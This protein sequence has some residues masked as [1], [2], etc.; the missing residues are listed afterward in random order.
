MK[1]NCLDIGII[2]AF[3]DGELVHEETARVSGHIATCDASALMLADAEEESAVVFPMLEREFNS[4]VP[5]QRLWNKISDSIAVEKQNMPFWQKAWAFFA[6]NLATPS[7]AAAASLLVVFG[8]VASIWIG[9]T[10]EQM[11]VAG[12]RPTANTPA[13]VTAVNA[14]DNKVVGDQVYR[15]STP[16]NIGVERAAYRPEPRRA[17]TRVYSDI[18]RPSANNATNGYLPGEESYVKTIA[19]LAKS[20]DAAKDTVMRPGD[21]IAYERDMAVVDDAIAKMRTE[22]KRNPKNESAKQVL[23][24]SYQNKIDLLNSV[25]QKEELVASLR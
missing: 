24:S 5:T 4:L 10:P 11:N 14:P 1:E 16:S 6:L 15:P 22:V 8:I 20:T 18:K 25:S 9:R 23:Y 19:S 21:R 17:D 12:L 2:Q 13:A 7:F 3:L